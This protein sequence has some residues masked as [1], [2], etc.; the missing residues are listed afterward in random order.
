MGDKRCP[1]TAWQ[2]R[3]QEVTQRKTQSLGK[4][5]WKGRGNEWSRIKAKAQEHGRWK[6]L[7]THL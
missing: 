4:K 6:S 2:A 1:K 7:F 5:I 3:T